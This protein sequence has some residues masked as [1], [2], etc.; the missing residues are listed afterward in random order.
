MMKLRR[1]RSAALSLGLLAFAL[2]PRPARAQ[3][4]DALLQAIQE[5]RPELVASILVKHPELA[6]E[7]DSRGESPLYRAAYM[8]RRKE[9]EQLITS[10]ADVNAVTK[11]GTPVLDAACST[12]ANLELVRLLVNNGANINVSDEHRRTPLHWAAYHGFADVVVLLLGRGAN[13]EARDD[14]GRRPL[15]LAAAA[16]SDDAVRLLLEHGV[17]PNPRDETGKTP[18]DLARDGHHGR[19]EDVVKRLTSAHPSPAPKGH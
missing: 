19:W 3:T 6:K 7:S 8:H 10:G 15:H 5:D 14:V 1:W 16:G 4:L 13:A 12:G 18:L 9:A 2:A 11:R 17:D